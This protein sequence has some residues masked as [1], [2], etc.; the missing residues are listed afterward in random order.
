M[1]VPSVVPTSLSQAALL[2]SWLV[3]PKHFE[4]SG[5]KQ[6]NSRTGSRLNEAANPNPSIFE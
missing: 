3:R 1:S 6:I 2:V 4:L 5:P